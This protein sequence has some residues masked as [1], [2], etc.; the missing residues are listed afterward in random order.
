MTRDLTVAMALMLGACGDD[1]VH[2]LPDAPPRI[3]AAVDAAVD[4]APDALPAHAALFALIDAKLVAVD[5]ATGAITE[6]GPTGQTWGVISWDDAAHVMRFVIDNYSPVGGA[7]TPRLGTIDLCT[8]TI[9][10]GPAITINGTQVRRAE[11]IVRDPSSG[12]WYAAFGTSGTAG[13]TQ[14]ISESNGT[15]DVATGAVTPHGSHTTLQNDGDLLF[16]AGTTLELLDVAT[17]SNSGATYAIDKTT[18]AATLVATTGP[19]VLRI[20]PDP[21]RGIAFA[22]YGATNATGRGVGT[23]DLTTGGVTPL[24]VS[25]PDATYPGLQFTGLASAPAPICP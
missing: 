9:T 10:P 20:A 21:T 15:V 18:G 5:P 16:F 19:T 13:A 2:H 8:G 6:I 22:S 14:Y 23:I 4:A 11:G 7:A 12:T 1:G 25:L 24:P 17:A 3:D